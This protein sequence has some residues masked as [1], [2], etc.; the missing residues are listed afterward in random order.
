[1]A[2]TYV[3]VPVYNMGGMQLPGM[4]APPPPLS[5]TSSSP[6]KSPTKSGGDGKSSAE[7]SAAEQVRA[8]CA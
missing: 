2:F 1:M 8:C 6:S 7:P 4:V 5:P 3:P